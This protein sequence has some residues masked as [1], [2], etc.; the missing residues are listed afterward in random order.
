M[1]PGPPT[2]LPMDLH[3]PA[4]HASAAYLSPG[5]L[6]CYLPNC[7]RLALLLCRASMLGIQALPRPD[8]PPK[9]VADWSLP[10]PYRA[11]LLV[12]ARPLTRRTHSYVAAH[13]ACP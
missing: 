3:H 8:K 13:R 4:A 10:C 11:L 12:P 5:C 6:P 1:K 9:R 2:R 7:R